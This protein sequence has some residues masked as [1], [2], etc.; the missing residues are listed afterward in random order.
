MRHSP[1]NLVVEDQPSLLSAEDG[2]KLRLEIGRLQR[3]NRSLSIAL[4][5]IERVAERD[6]LTPLYNRRYFLSALHQ[7]IARVDRDHGR[8][9]LIYADVNGLKAI[10]DQHGHCAGDL[11]LI[12]FAARMTTAMR[13]ND[14]LARIGGD[15]FGMLLDHVSHSEAKAFVR[16]LKAIT[17]DEPMEYEGKQIKLSAAFGVAMVDRGSS[18][19]D[20]IG[21]ADTNMYLAKRRN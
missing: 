18:A 3:E 21:L 19:E 13:R 8:V 20:L 2:A 5:E 14:V 16:R 4:S 7:R 15:E 12:E 17:G 1:L 10:N 11:A 9:A 6:M